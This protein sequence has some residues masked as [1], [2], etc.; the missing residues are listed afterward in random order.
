M[1]AESGELSQE[2]R[3]YQMPSSSDVAVSFICLQN[4]QNLSAALP[5]AG[6]AATESSLSGVW[7]QFPSRGG[8]AAGRR[9][10]CRGIRWQSAAPQSLEAAL[11]EPQLPIGAQPLAV[12]V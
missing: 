2:R 8:W 12:S 10:R 7:L 3:K 5:C 9:R 1:Y 6:P 4:P 11:M